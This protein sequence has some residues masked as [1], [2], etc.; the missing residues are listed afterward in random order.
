MDVTD[1]EVRGEIL[2]LLA[3]QKIGNPDPEFYRRWLQ[4]TFRETPVQF[5][6]QVRELL[7]IRKLM[8]QVGS[9]LAGAANEATGEKKTE[10]F[11]KWNQ[12]LMARANFKDYL[13]RSG[14]S[15]NPDATPPGP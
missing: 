6:R 8:R 7:R 4:N 10:R 9:D 15:E 2:R 14:D 13:P 11:L 3:E 5:E 12:E 1:E